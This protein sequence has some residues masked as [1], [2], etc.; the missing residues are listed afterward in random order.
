LFIT[1]TVLNSAG[2][3]IVGTITSG[4][5]V[6]SNTSVWKPMSIPITYSNQAAAAQ[7]KVNF[8]MQYTLGSGVHLNSYFVIDDVT[9]SNTA[10]IGID[11]I[12]ASTKL[13]IFPN[14]V[15]N[16]LKIKTEAVKPLQ[17]TLSDALG[18][19]VLHRLSENPVNGFI[20]DAIN[21]ESLSS[22]LYFLMV[23]SDKKTLVRRVIVE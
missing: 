5:A 21:T 10:L 12:E 1:A 17:I 14:P 8:T 9:M 4:N 22:G 6:T 23:T 16:S 18:R 13:Q 2:S 19:V 11:E 15:H 7:A 20:Q 3:T